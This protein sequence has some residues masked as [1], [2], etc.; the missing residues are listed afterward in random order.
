MT[1]TAKNAAFALAGGVGV[2]LAAPM[3]ASKT[4]M[5]S[6]YAPAGVAAVVGALLLATS[7]SVGIDEK[8]GYGAIAAA[9]ALAVGAYFIE[10]AKED[11]KP[12]INLGGMH[13]AG[14]LRLADLKRMAPNSYLRFSQPALEEVSQ[15]EAAGIDPRVYVSAQMAADHANVDARLRARGLR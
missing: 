2:A 12:K 13:M 6:S 4:N 10:K 9:G 5:T 7:K 14:A 1:S 15:L 11:M 3:L 8:I